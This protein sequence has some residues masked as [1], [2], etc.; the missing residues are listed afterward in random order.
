MLG[1]RTRKATSRCRT[2]C[3]DVRKKSIQLHLGATRCHNSPIADSN[4]AILWQRMGRRIAFPPNLVLDERPPVT[5]FRKLSAIIQCTLGGLGTSAFRKL[6]CTTKELFVTRID[7]TML[8]FHGSGPGNRSF[9]RRQ[10]LN[11]CTQIWN[12]TGE[13]AIPFLPISGQTIP[14]DRCR[15]NLAI[16]PHFRHIRARNALIRSWWGLRC[17]G[18]VRRCNRC[19]NARSRIS[20]GGTPGAI[21]PFRRIFVQP[22]GVSRIA[23]TAA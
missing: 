3:K 16:M 10:T 21:F 15:P 9:E 20:A 7:H 14:L 19:P 2:E 8:C 22:S 5:R 11:N 18:D 13:T 4:A 12:E 23:K 1:W 17:E 6:S